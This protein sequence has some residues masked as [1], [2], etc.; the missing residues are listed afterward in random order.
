MKYRRRLLSL[1]LLL[2]AVIV[3]AQESSPPAGQPSTSAK[4]S[5]TSDAGVP[6]FKAGPGMTS[7]RA[8]YAPNPQYTDKAR[9]AKINGTVL[10]QLTVTSEG[11]ARDVKVTKSLTPD[12]DQKA[13]EA[14][15]SWKF[16]PA[17]KNGKPITVAINVEATFS[18]Y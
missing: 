18:L 2:A 14:V 8:V 15:R 6:I 12:L 5:E 9:K 13:V 16:K 7:P 1:L 10:L 11:E 3:C 17:T 4:D